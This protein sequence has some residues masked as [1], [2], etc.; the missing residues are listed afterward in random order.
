MAKKR[1][2]KGRSTRQLNVPSRGVLKAQ[3]LLSQNR[4][5]LALELS[6]VR[7]QTLVNV[8][9]DAPPIARRSRPARL[10][11]KPDNRTYHPA[12]KLRPLTT[13]FLT[14]SVR[15]KV[16][17]K[18]HQLA[19]KKPKRVNVCTSRSIR[20]QL[21]FALG[22][23]GRRGRQRKHRLNDESKISCKT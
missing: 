17:R 9:R 21:L 8:R 1:R 14:P 13:T 20:R 11:L 3:D 22:M 7:K 19:F 18:I 2:K 4:H 15:L 12:G 6:R 10:V 5:R 16:G 23:G